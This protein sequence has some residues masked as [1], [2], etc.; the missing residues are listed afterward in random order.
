MKFRLKSYF[1]IFVFGLPG[2]HSAAESRE[3]DSLIKKYKEINGSINNYNHD[4]LFVFLGIQCSFRRVHWK[5]DE[6][7]IVTMQY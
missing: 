6:T 2:T 7:I 1:F 5:L 4:N 3:T